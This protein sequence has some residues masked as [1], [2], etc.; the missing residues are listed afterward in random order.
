MTISGHAHMTNITLLLIHLFNSHTPLCATKS[1]R[2]QAVCDIV[3]MHAPTWGATDLHQQGRD[4]EIVSIH[5]PTWGATA[6]F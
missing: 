3:S 2:L 5:A 4:Y 1:Y 6:T